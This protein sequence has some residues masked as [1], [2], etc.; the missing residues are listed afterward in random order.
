MS[1]PNSDLEVEARRLMLARVVAAPDAWRGRATAAGGFLGAAAAL[2]FV[3]LSS[4]SKRF[5]DWTL[6]VA[7]ISTVAYVLAVCAFLAASVWPPPKPRTET[8]TNYFDTTHDYAR[9][10]SRPIRR[11]VIFGA[12]AAA[13]A[14]T[15]TAICSISLLLPPGAQSGVQVTLRDRA[16]MA[17]LTSLCPGL[18]N[19]FQATVLVRGSDGVELVVTDARCPGGRSVF[20]VPKDSVTM[21]GRAKGE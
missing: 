14:I 17:A 9:D 13:S 11:C 5:P 19:P 12:C 15:G 10:E 6:W 1:A 21:L 20:T 8:T 4:S 16:D 2:A 7:G 18:P 3:G